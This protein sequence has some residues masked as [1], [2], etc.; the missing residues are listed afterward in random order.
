MV[1]RRGVSATRIRKGGRKGEGDREEGERE[2]S[3]ILRAGWRRNSAETIAHE[4]E[5]KELGNKLKC[6]R[7]CSLPVRK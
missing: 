4:R 5:R 2:G 7:L 3:L 1:G 6:L